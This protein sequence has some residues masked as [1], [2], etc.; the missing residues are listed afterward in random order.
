MS[1]KAPLCQYLPR[2]VS[3]A[4]AQSRP[5]RELTAVFMEIDSPIPALSHIRNVRRP[6]PAIRTHLE[7][8]N[9]L[10]TV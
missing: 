4:C 1:T 9:N 7:C 2:W 6:I 10:F 5:A 8:E 3:Q